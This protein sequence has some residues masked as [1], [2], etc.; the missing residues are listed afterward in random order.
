MAD[1]IEEIKAKID[2]VEIVGEYVRLQ[3]A[4]TYFKACC[5]FH[6]EKTPSFTVSPSKQI[7]HCFGC[8]TGGDAFSFLMKQEGIAFP[9]AL[10]LLAERAGVTLVK[11]DPQAASKRNRL[12]DLLDLATGFF[13]QA[14]LRSVQGQIARDYLLKRGITQEIIDE[15]MI[16]YSLPEYDRLNEFLLGRKF[17][18]AE[19]LQ[20]GLAVQKEK[21]YGMIDRFRG[22]LMIPIRNV[23]GQIIG[24]G[25]RVLDEEDKGAKYINS[26]QTELY[27]KSRTVFGL[28][29][30][31]NHIRTTDAAVLVEGYMDFLASYQ[32]GIKNVVASSGTA[33]TV[34]QIRLI[35]RFTQNFLFS[36]DTD[37]A[38]VQATSRGIE[39]V[40]KE[41]IN[42]KVV[43]LPKD[44]SGNSIY[45]DPDECINKNPEDWMKAI[46]DAVPF[47]QY[48]LDQQLSSGVPQDAFEKKKIV[49]KLLEIISWLP[50]KIEQDHW[51]KQ[52][53]ARVQV[54]E[55]ILWEVLEG[56]ARPVTPFPGDVRVKTPLAT[57]NAKNVVLVREHYVLALLIK[58]PNLIA[59][60]SSM[61]S[62]EVWT[63]EENRALYEFLITAYNSKDEGSK[64]EPIDF[65]QEKKTPEH[66]LLGML[67]MLGTV[68][69][70]WP[71]YNLS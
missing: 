4:G 67:E 53:A 69:R 50:D 23:H 39:M 49:R 26:P 1:P 16:G 20:V 31:K 46:G 22:R 14:F 36:F 43:I 8:N 34:E 54:G 19:I 15:F 6:Q 5:P 61:L 38:G 7:W 55:R 9:E 13:H 48:S 35:K 28:D 11:Q 27:D 70:A 40:L 10:R 66:P 45:K 59:G 71:T 64:D 25:G 60:T 2:V 17:T 57:T 47:V 41:G 63:S 51:V 37:S 29:K 3:S 65:I 21:G 18:A 24:F 42:A 62:D 32:V 12:L 68:V 52:L 58:Y 56:L 33:L 30:A 44:D